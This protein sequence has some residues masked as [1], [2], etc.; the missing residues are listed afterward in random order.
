MRI[1]IAV[2]CYAATL[3]PG[4][5]SA[6]R[7]VLEALGDDVT[8][9]AGRCCGQAPFNSGY[10]AEAK[11]A[12]REL[13]KAI[14][15]FDHVVMLSGSCTAMI[16]HY[17]PML[18]EG[19]RR[20][21]A[22]AIGHRVSDLATYLANHPERGRLDLRLEGAVAYHDSCHA[23]RELRATAATTEVLGS[24]EGLDVRRLGYEEE[25]CGFGGSF[26]MK[27]PEVSVEI[28]RAKLDDVAATGARVLVGDLSCVTHLQAGA[29]GL[30][31]ELETW[32]LAELLAE[33]LS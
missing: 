28:M 32:T 11:T 12:G 26:S 29:N 33:A 17:L 27:L 1:A 31:Q 24:I 9:I 16:Q 4:E 19:S 20:E 18:F 25:C 22:S 2:P 21:G 7:R 13:L 23:R 5:A 8:M 14:Q 6:A 10:R 30:G 3:R 15:P